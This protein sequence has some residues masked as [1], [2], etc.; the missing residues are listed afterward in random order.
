M[1]TTR[2]AVA[3]NPSP[4]H[5]I[6]A[7]RVGQYFDEVEKQE[8]ALV[9]A[10]FTRAKGLHSWGKGYFEAYAARDIDAVMAH[11]TPDVTIQSPESFGVM[12][13]WDDIRA[14]TY[15]SYVALP[16]I[17]TYPEDGPNVLPFWDFTGPKTRVLIPWR[18]IGRFTG[19]AK[20]PNWPAMAGTGRCIDF[21]GFDRY[22]LTDDWKIEKILWG[23]D[24]LAMAQQIGFAPD[25]RHPVV[26]VAAAIERRV[27]PLLRFAESRRA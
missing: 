27:A 25:L 1:S 11:M 20:F 6:H 8:Q 23:F 10:G 18:V 24:P 19:V 5:A 7:A 12:N 13:G 2:S 16:D 26:S 21:V 14:Y 3:V 9:A 15:N 4:V 17:V 22:V